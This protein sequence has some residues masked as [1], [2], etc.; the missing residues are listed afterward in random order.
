MSFCQYLNQNN[1][2]QHNPTQLQETRG[3]GFVRYFHK[4]D[5]EKAIE[6]LDGFVSPW[7]S[8]LACLPACI[9]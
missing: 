5:A 7:A 6:K 3:F 4:E 9:L 1:P 2:I 8:L